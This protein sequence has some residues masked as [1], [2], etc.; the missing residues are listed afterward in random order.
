[1]YFCRITS[2]PYIFYLFRMSV[3][4]YKCMEF[5]VI[6]IN[7]HALCHVSTETLF[8]DITKTKNNNYFPFFDA[9]PIFT[10]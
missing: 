1:M 5:I 8:N 10:T 6:F 7:K 4:K 9:K 2:L 3:V